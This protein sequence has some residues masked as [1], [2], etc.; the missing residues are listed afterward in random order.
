[1]ENIQVHFVAKGSNPH[2]E[3]ER[4]RL[5]AYGVQYAIIVDQGSRPGP[6]LVP[7]AKNLLVD[8]HFSDEFPDDTVVRFHDR[9]SRP[10]SY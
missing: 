10:A 4:A 1:M 5:A 3:D 7:G 8:H 2:R 9:V 6:V